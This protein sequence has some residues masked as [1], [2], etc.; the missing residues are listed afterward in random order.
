MLTEYVT[1]IISVVNES[2]YNIIMVFQ[3]KLTN[4]EI[5]FIADLA[6]NKSKTVIFAS[7]QTMLFNNNKNVL[8]V[9]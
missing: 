1:K 2:T 9:Q 3:S 4:E 8:S 5:D 6:I 7:V